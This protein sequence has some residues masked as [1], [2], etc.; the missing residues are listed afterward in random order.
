MSSVE[1]IENQEQ[2]LRVFF[3]RIGNKL[4]DGMV[5]VSENLTVMSAN[6]S[7]Q[8]IF[9]F[10]QNDILGK[11]LIDYLV[12]KKDR[13][14]INELFNNILFGETIE[15][16]KVI[17]KARDENKTAVTATYIPVTLGRR[18][19]AII[20]LYK[21]I[22]ESLQ[23]MQKKVEAARINSFEIL[24]R[25]I[26]TN[27]QTIMANTNKFIQHGLKFLHNQEISNKFFYNATMSVQESNV[28]VKEYLE[29]LKNR[30]S[31]V[32]NSIENIDQLI[33]FK[34][35]EASNTYIETTEDVDEWKNSNAKVY[36]EDEMLSLYTLRKAKLFEMVNHLLSKLE[37]IHESENI[38]MDLSRKKVDNRNPIVGL[39]T[40]D[41][42]KITF[43]LY[44]IDLNSKII[45][46]TIKNF[47]QQKRNVKDI[48]KEFGSIYSI[49]KNH[50]GFFGAISLPENQGTNLFFY[51]PIFN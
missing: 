3:R 20:I 4:T 30:D 39:D 40:G 2:V 32:L 24:S 1:N 33:K 38:L 17:L 9:G 27:L 22:T 7:F 6:R 19:K 44:N 13:E 43:S 26:V 45:Q 35:P 8:N 28:L 31:F 25:G 11:K 21:N 41:Y 50:I 5:V 10:S 47:T 14:E 36:G 42:I 49:V 18:R 29:F 46:N 51:V 15:N 12:F 34:P 16:K 37:N 48:D 23:L